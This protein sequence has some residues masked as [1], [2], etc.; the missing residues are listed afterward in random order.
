MVEVLGDKCVKVMTGLST[1][2]IYDS[3]SEDRNLLVGKEVF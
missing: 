2:S 1:L 3:E